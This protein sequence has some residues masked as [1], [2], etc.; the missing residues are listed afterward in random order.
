MVAKFLSQIA[1]VGYF[2]TVKWPWWPSFKC[3]RR[4][5]LLLPMKLPFAKDG[6]AGISRDE[7]REW[8]LQIGC[9]KRISVK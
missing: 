4:V 1:L 3:V 5:A 6:D 7:H 8:D 9:H 2:S